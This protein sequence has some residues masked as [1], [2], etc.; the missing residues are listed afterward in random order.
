MEPAIAVRGVVFDLDGLLV[1]SEP[2]QIAAWQAFL[3]GHGKR[4]DEGLL[5][6]LFG[7]RLRDSARLVIERLGLSLTLEQVLAERD[8]IFLDSLA[9]QLRAMPG[10][11]E[12]VT[13]L[14]ERGVP[15]GLATS[16]HR[17]YVE[18]ALVEI[19]LA[20]AFSVVVTAEDVERGKP[21][22][23]CYRLAVDRLGLP[24]EACL[25]L[26]DAPLGVRAARAAGLRCLA[27]PNE[28]TRSLPGLEEADAILP[29]LCE[30]LPWLEAQG[31]MG[32]TRPE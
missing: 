12:L 27:I 24:P 26:E 19:G 21:A 20:S 14:A 1:D 18:R 8:A 3:A 32:D 25:A 6:E 22:P 5:N 7:L 11:R 15:L 31:W 30:V 28:H 23:D 9:G 13:E 4:L 16:G 2:L 29:S 10:A 17:H